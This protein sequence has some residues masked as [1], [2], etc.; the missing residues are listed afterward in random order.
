ML[1]RCLTA[2]AGI[3]F[4]GIAAWCGLAFVT[5]AHRPGNSI[6]LLLAGFGV[7]LAIIAW[8]LLD[9]ANQSKA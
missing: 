6:Q 4:G 3:A 8:T 9:L 7:L 1:R 2:A 5:G